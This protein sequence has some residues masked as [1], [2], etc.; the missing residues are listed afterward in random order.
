MNTQRI[1]TVAGTVVA[2]VLIGAFIGLGIWNNGQ[3]KRIK[4]NTAQ[5]KTNTGNAKKAMDRSNLA[6]VQADSAK[7]IS[8]S[9][10]KVSVAAANNAA[11]A[12]EISRIADSLARNA[13]SLA[14]LAMKGVN[15]VKTGLAH[16]MTARLTINR[17]AAAILYLQKGDISKESADSIVTAF[18][19][20]SKGQATNFYLACGVDSLT[21]GL[22]EVDPCAKA[23]K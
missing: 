7:G 15:E 14:Q 13:D 9:V 17:L 22:K 8:K 21:L 5:I 16:D 2:V 4:A 6:L 12:T 20:D 10:E 18:V 1:L 11:Y 3:E 23:S 19:T